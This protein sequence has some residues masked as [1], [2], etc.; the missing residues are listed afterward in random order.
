NCY[1]TVDRGVGGKSL[2]RRI[3]GSAFFGAWKIH[4][5]GA[6]VIVSSIRQ[7]YARRWPAHCG[8]NVWVAARKSATGRLERVRNGTGRGGARQRDSRY[9]TRVAS[10]R[11]KQSCALL[12]AGRRR[13]DCIVDEDLSSRGAAE[14][15]GRGGPTR[16]NR[17]KEGISVA[18]L[19]GGVPSRRKI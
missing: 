7:R 1:R 3:R 5:P 6:D 10:R 8:G 13:V 19:L 16:V 14:I 4:A 17:S 12:V 11:R 2:S 9:R 15:A 18:L